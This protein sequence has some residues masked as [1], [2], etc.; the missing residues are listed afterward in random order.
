MQARK[1]RS[2]VV[3]FLA[4]QIEKSGRTVEDVAQQAGMNP[5]M[6][7]MILEGESKLAF[8]QVDPMANAL[9]VEPVFVLRLA[10]EDALPQV[11]AIVQEKLAELAVS[12]YERKVLQ[13]YRRLSQGRDIPVVMV[14]G[15]DHVEVRPPRR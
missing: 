3:C 2:V 13:G 4:E 9:G 10:L 6:L 15:F 7:R 5:T 1:S 12:D 8:N 14:P 11:W